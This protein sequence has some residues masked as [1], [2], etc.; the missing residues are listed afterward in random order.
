MKFAIITHVSHGKT[1]DGYFAYAPYVREM[2]IW[3]KY[4]D[5]VTIVAPMELTRQTAIESCY[6]HPEITFVPVKSFDI[7]GFRS[8]LKS[9]VALPGIFHTVF[10]TM[11][12]ADHIHLRC[13]GNMGLVGCIAQ[14]FFPK[15]KKTVKYAGNW[16]PAAKQPFTYRLQKYILGNTFLSRN[17]TVLAY[18]TWSGSSMNIK[19]FF[20]ASYSDSDKI[21]I[22]PRSFD[23]AIRFIFVGTLSSGKRPLYAVKLIEELAKHTK[24]IRLDFYGEGPERERIEA[25]VKNHNLE[26]TVQLHGNRDKE[27][28]TSA[29]RASHFAI[30]A[31]KSEGWPKAVAEAMFWGCVPL[32]SNVSCVAEMLGHGTRGMLL[33]TNLVNDVAMMTELLANENKYRTM[34]VQAQ[35][36]S[37]GFTI[38]KFDHEIQK[39][40]C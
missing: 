38:E 33:E 4:V 28:V 37:Q 11:R 36:W 9:I 23:S 15:K 8:I 40:L 12:S 24:D 6:D 34:S 2:N 10:R 30:L 35:Q 21:A 26:R 27:A 31:S 16:D 20:T 25:Y 3:T 39:L 18:G 14:I 5:Q 17:I 1:D 29:Y 13:P 22:A 32:V 19:P 7:K